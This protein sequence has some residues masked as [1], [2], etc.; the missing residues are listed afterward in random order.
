MAHRT[1]FNDIDFWIV[2]LI[3]LLAIH[4]AT[5]ESIGRLNLNYFVLTAW[6]P[7]LLGIL[8][9]SFII[10]YTPL[11]YFLKRKRPNLNKRLLKMHIFGNSISFM[12]VTLH[13]IS[14]LIL[15]PLGIGVLSYLFVLLLMS[16]GFSYRFGILKPLNVF[17]KDI[18]HYNRYLHISLT[19]SFYIVFLFHLLKATNFQ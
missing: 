9:A 8:G 12:F 3:Y 16:S 14:N 1:N 2:V 15:L 7:H 10:V 5:V 4:L 6:L 18:P 13:M 19:I 17:M 11:F